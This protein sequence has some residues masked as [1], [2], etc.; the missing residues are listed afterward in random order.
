L[1]VS[2][3]YIAFP[4]ARFVAPF[5]D[6]GQDPDASRIVD[7]RPGSNLVKRAETALA[8]ATGGIHRADIDTG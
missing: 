1:F 2:A 8:Q 3:A 4:E 7:A 5:S 6:F